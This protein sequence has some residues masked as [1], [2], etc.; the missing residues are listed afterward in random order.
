MDPEQ[1]EKKI[2]ELEQDISKEIKKGQLKIRT[3]QT[4]Q[5]ELQKGAE[6]ITSWKQKVEVF[7]EVLDK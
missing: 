5:T 6:K 2:K 4:L 1:I 7:R 3:I